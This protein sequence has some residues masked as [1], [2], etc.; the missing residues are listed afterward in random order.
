VSA[1]TAM[2]VLGALAAAMVSLALLR[3]PVFW[4]VPDPTSLLAHLPGAGTAHG[5]FVRLRH[6]GHG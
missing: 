3:A 6:L 2:V 5:T 1:F 4:P